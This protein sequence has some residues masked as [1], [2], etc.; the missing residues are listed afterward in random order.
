MNL[1]SYQQALI[2]KNQNNLALAITY[3]E[4]SISECSFIKESFLE[5]ANIYS[6]NEDFYNK[7]I[8][9]YEKYLE[10]DSKKSLVFNI[11]GH[12]YN[13]TGNIEKSYEYLSKALLLDP[14]DKN[15]ISNKLFALQKL[16]NFSQKEIF[17]IT[18]SCIN[19]YKKTINIKKFEHKKKKNKDKI[20]IGYL[21]GDFNQHVIMLYLLPILEN[22]DRNN[23]NITCYSNTKLEEEDLYTIK[24][25]LASDNFRNIFELSDFEL[26][27][28][29]YEDNIDI[30][31]DLSGHTAKSRVFT[32]MYKP[33]PIQVSYL[34]FPN[35]TGIDE[36][37]Y[38]LTNKNLNSIKEE[39]NFS[40]KLYFLDSCYRCF[41]P[42]EKMIPD[43]NELPMIKNNYITFGIFNDLSKINESVYEI[44]SQILHQ[45]KNSKL[46]IC[47]N[48]I[49]EK[50]IYEK[51]AK[52][53]IERNRLI[54]DKEFDLSKYNQ[55]DIH[56][57][58]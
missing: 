3:F 20:H 9:F 52:Y 40:E 41:K 47:R 26:S 33:A 38:F 39:N 53:G 5:L 57:V 37:D 17:D 16:D 30:L 21:S 13:R 34:G 54:L 43:F 4:K 56:I 27:K 14:S 42:D 36:I 22:H 12:L 7:A 44:W 35:T 32:T 55:V 46:F 23:F 15:I 2:W 48:T 25:E 6:I 28:T 18:K 45:V 50:T 29:I 24:A 8:F 10:L 31:V 1:N 58:V 19:E 51:F 11:L 49:I